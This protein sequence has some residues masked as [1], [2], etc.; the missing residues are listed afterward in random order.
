MTPSKF[1]I[2]RLGALGDIIHTIPAVAALRRALPSA[3]IDWL[4]DAR[5][6]E[7]LDLVPVISR[8][9]SIPARG[10][11]EIVSVTG[12]LRRE[13]YD[14]ALDLQGL[15]KSAVLARASGASRVIGFPAEMLRERSARFFY[16]ET[17]GEA[18]THVIDKNLSM[19]RAFG[20]RMPERE[21]PIEDRKPKVVT[22]ARA[23]LNVSPTDPFIVLNPGAA[24]LNKRW[25]PVYFAEVARELVKRRGLRSLV[26]WG[27]GERQLAQD[28]VT[29]SD[30]SA[31]VAPETT[32]ADL[33]SLLKAASLLVSGDTGP[34]HV[35]GALGTPVV[36]IFGPTDPSRNGPWAEEDLT[37][38]RY[39]VCACHYQRRCHV[40]G[41]CLLDISPKE[42]VDLV[43]RRLHLA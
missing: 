35:A 7:L 21:F 9:I 18:S 36:G 13:R 10:V 29:A 30:G 14:V 40:A 8:R 33:V 2:V 20:V 27:P 34:M 15:L 12:E 4:V 6:R 19:L 41:W 42:V 28:V 37:V 39:Q 23:A 31:A 1:L 17:A 5:H 22:A 25:P 11:G 24:W 26:M 38:S 16:T 3:T 43:D 32:I